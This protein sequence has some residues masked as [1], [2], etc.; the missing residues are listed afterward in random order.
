M[1][2][3]EK[4]KLSV[5][6]SVYNEE[7]AL[8][9]YYD[10]ATI[11]LAGLGRDYEL[12]FVNDGSTDGSAAFLRQL[13][14][15]DAC[16]KVISFSRNFGHESAMIAGIDHADGDYII[17]MDAD[18]QHPVECIAGIAEKLDD[19]Y[20]VVSMVRGKNKDAGAVK[21]LTSP[22][23]Y[24]VI[25]KISDS[26]ME[27]NASDFFGISRRVAEVLKDNYR[28][29]IRFLR[30]YVQNVGF[31]K[32]VLMYDA[33]N[34]AAGTSKYTVRKL[35]RLSF[36]TIMCFSDAP[37]KLG[38]Y[39]GIFSIIIG[40]AMAVYTIVSWASVG[41]P[42][43]YASIIV[44]ICFMFAVLFFILGIMGEYISVLFAEIKNR[45][46]YIIEEKIGFKE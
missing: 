29:K 17:C 39:A 19:G 5:V 32:T 45:P 31:R 3:T 14:E 12:L 1:S 7:E 46:I 6:V 8:P 43:G 26:K 28:E 11:K 18:L 42:N 20:D 16:V 27:K 2:N 41:T 33:G 23:F 35:F 21:N 22:A 4:R 44:L 37:L 38:I 25:N 15:A 9:L 10:A 13:A 40:I 36:N 24:A 34:R 30:G